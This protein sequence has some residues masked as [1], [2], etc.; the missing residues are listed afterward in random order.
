MRRGDIYWA[1]LEPRRSKG[2]QGGTRPFIIL[3]DDA[4]NINPGWTTVLGVPVTSSDRCRTRGP[5]VVPLLAGAGGLKMDSF[6]ICYQATTLGKE[7][8]TRKIGTLSSDE[9]SRVERGLLAAFGIY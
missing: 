6:A 3:S 5:A 7:K 9:V 1:N 2:E 8:L 4:F